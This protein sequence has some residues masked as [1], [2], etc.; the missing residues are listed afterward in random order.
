MLPSSHGEQEHRDAAPNQ[1]CD[2]SAC[3]TFE[4]MLSR[5]GKLRVF[6][7][8]YTLVGMKLHCKL[9]DNLYG[10]CVAL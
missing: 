1:L 6:S 10:N 4:T 7:I 2:T 8:S 9:G 3:N 5:W